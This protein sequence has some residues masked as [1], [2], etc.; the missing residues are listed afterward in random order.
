MCREPKPFRRQILLAAGGSL[1]P[2]FA[3]NALAQT[4]M[5]MQATVGVLHSG[6]SSR[7][8]G[9]TVRALLPHLDQL[10]WTEGRNLALIERYAAG[11]LERTPQLAAELVQARPQVIVA[12]LSGTDALALR[13]ATSTIPIVA[14]NTL[15]PV[16]IGLAQSLARPGG[17]RALHRRHGAGG[18]DL[19]PEH[20]ANSTEER[21][22]SRCGVQGHARGRR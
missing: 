12:G 9:P 11:H 14:L 10:G 20:V 6:Q 15:D 5:P 3:S 21:R 2:W 4:G 13:R 18:E 1:T 19:G 22:R 16:C 8:S 17:R 7:D